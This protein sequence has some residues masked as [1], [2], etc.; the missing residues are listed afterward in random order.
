MDNRLKILYEDSGLLVCDKPAGVAVQSRSYGRQDLEGM[1]RAYLMRQNGRRDNFVSPVHRLDQPVEGMVVF[2]KAREAAAALT[3]QIQEHRWVKEYLAVTEGAFVKEEGCLVDYLKKD[4]GSGSSYVVPKSD[5]GGKRSVLQ[6]GVLETMDMQ[7]L[8]RVALMT[9]RHHQI[10]VQLRHAGHPIIG[11]MRYNKKSANQGGRASLALAAC[12]LIFMH[13]VTD[14]E[15]VFTRMP[16]G[17][18]FEKFRD[19]IQEIYH[20]V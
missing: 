2:A 6:Y 19:V 1:V 7:Q 11:D 3:R 9:G 8:V 18:E 14:K 15:M 10:R 4:G 20:M 17:S 16:T 13:P 12:K 5:R